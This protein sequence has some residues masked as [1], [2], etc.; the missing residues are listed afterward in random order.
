VRAEK[1][2]HPTTSR[3]NV[4]ELLWPS[5][6]CIV[7][8]L[9]GFFLKVRLTELKMGPF[10]IPVDVCGPQDAH[11]LEDVPTGMV[12]GLGVLRTLLHLFHHIGTSTIPRIRT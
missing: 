10:F 6:L 12:V 3:Y 7:P 11:M 1:K 5:A 2:I 4:P 9:L 8:V